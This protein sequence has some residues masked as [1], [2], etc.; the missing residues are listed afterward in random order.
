MKREIKALL[1]AY[2]QIKSEKIELESLQ[3]EKEREFEDGDDAR[4]SM[5]ADDE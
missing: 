3:Q 1:E 5:R 2:L 4:S